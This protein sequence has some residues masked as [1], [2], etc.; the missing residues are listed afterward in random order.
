MQSLKESDWV[1]QVQII[2]KIEENIRKSPGNN[3]SCSGQLRWS[4]TFQQE[5]VQ[6]K[7]TG[8]TH[9][10]KAVAEREP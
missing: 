8:E 2:K 6:R 3:F 5:Q 7:A 1:L 4:D 9:R 10:R